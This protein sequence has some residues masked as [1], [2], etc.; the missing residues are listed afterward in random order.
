VVL[1]QSPKAVEEDQEMEMMRKE[2]EELKPPSKK[3]LQTRRQSKGLTYFDRLKPKVT[4]EIG[5]LEDWYTERNLQPLSKR[6]RLNVTVDDVDSGSDQ[7]EESDEEM[8]ELN[9]TLDHKLDKSL[10]YENWLE[11]FEKQKKLQNKK[12]R[13]RNPNSNSVRSKSRSPSPIKADPL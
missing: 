7:S 5:S 11:E 12:K 6:R 8:I 4:I 13:K 2:T 3:K 10:L 9:K 1:S